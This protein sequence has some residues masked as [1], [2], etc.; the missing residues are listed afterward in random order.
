MYV[1]QRM[2]QGGGYVTVS[3]HKSSFTKRLE[4]A[5][6]YRDRES[7]EADRC[8]QNERVI[9]LTTLLQNPR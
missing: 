2:D 3:G 8:P 4:E 9:A 1:I 6:I 5:R 7:A